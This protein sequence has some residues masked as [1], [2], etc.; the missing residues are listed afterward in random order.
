MRVLIIS[1]SAPRFPG[2]GGETRE[3]SLL[4]ELGARHEI[5]YAVGIFDRANQRIPYEMS[6]L[7]QAVIPLSFAIEKPATPEWLNLLPPSL[8][9]R[10]KRIWHIIGEPPYW[11]M[12][13]G[14]AESPIRDQILPHCLEDFDLVQVEHSNLRTAPDERFSGRPS[15]L[16]F[17][18]VYAAIQRRLL[19]R[20]SGLQDRILDWTEWKKMARHERRQAKSFDLSIA[21]SDKD[22]ESLQQIEPRVE[23]AVVPNGV[24]THY[25][26]NGHAAD[27][28]SD[29][30][31]FTGLMSYEPNVFGMVRFCEKIMPRV[32]QMRP[33]TRLYCVGMEPTEQVRD[34]ETKF[35]EHVIVTGAVEDVRPFIRRAAVVVVP[36]WDGGGTR[37]KILEALSMRKAVVS[38]GIGAEGLVLVSGKHL[39]IADDDKNFADAVVELQQNSAMRKELGKAGRK[40]VEA[41]Y[42]WSSIAPLQEAAWER[43]L[44]LHKQGARQLSRLF[45]RSSD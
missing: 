35:P 8:K 17:H 39:V 30:L 15:V 42:D 24:D 7:C 45:R 44:S 19:T 23:I 9:Q 1:P 41:Q 10:A 43:A 21:V 5:T 29:S 25:F 12:G 3:F 28:D 37:L 18:N 14:Q 2:S 4:R 11:V 20:A 40:L 27:E 26:N 34:L 16:S 22:A 32:M 6:E 36:L 33:N 38:T 13:R 31:V